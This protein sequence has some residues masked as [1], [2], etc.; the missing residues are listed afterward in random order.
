MNRITFIETIG[1]GTI[2]LGFAPGIISCEKKS[3]HR[4]VWEPEELAS[5][6][7]REQLVLL[8]SKYR[9]LS[10]EN[11]RDTLIELLTKNFSG[12]SEEQKKYL[13]ALVSDDFRTNQTVV[14][15]GWLLSRTEA[16]QCA[17]LSFTSE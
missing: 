4:S 7:Q 17:L 1:L 14:I 12:N 2:L 10:G 11:N 8:G 16:R 5:I 3:S 6:C 9:E 13:R 15:D